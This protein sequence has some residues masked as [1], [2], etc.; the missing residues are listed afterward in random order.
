MHDVRV[1]QSTL[2]YTPVKAGPNTH[3]DP[4]H[5]IVPLPPTPRQKLT[6]GHDTLM[7]PKSLP[8]FKGLAIDHETPFHISIAVPP[9]AAQNVG[10]TQETDDKVVAVPPSES[11]AV[12][13]QTRPFHRFACGTWKVV[14]L[15]TAMQKDEL[16]QST[17][18][19]PPLVSA[20]GRVMDAHAEP[21]HSSA[22]GVGIPAE[23]PP[24]ATQKTA[25]AQETSFNP[26]VVPGKDGVD[27]TVQ[28]PYDEAWA[29]TGATCPTATTQ[30]TA[31]A[32]RLVRSPRWITVRLALPLV[33]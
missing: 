8:R 6:V 7:S 29:D 11:A 20:G 3:E 18:Y 33:I 23:V 4:F 25:L 1:V 16:R 15:P 9:T 31:T 5:S 26:L 2:L 12:L 21:F 22:I 27:V 30:R 10:V 19:K 13:V 28:V 17:P 14:P 32:A 24:T